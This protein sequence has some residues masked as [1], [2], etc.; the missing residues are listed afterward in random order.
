MGLEDKSGPELMGDKTRDIMEVVEKSGED[1]L[2]VV[3][4]QEGK[5]LVE[6]EDKVLV[7]MLLNEAG[8]QDMEMV[9]FDKLLV[10]DKMLHVV[11]EQT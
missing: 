3:D 10:V 6:E 2:K 5:Q 11:E 4:K 1:M 8:M 9:L 7:D